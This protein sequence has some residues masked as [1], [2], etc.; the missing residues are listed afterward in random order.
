MRDH[1]QPRI[2]ER[3]EDLRNIEIQLDAVRVV[4]RCDDR[5]RSHEA[6]H[7]DAAQTEAP[8]ERGRDDRVRKPR[9]RRRD[10]S[11]VRFAPRGDPGQL[12]LGH[13]VGLVQLPETLVLGLGLGQAGPSRGEFRRGFDIFELR[14][15]G[16]GFHELALLEGHL[17]ER[18][19]DDRPDFDGFVGTRVAQGFHGQ[20]KGAQFHR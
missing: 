13:H 20:G 11:E 6:A 8:G 1:F 16:A 5:V 15:H 4:K 12:G 17:H 9:L 2:Q 14:Q 3:Q 7:A 10:G 19:G 18:R